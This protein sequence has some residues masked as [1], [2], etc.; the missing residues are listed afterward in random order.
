M[1]PMLCAPAGTRSLLCLPE[2]R[3]SCEANRA[4]ACDS[5]E[6]GRGAHGGWAL[7]VAAKRTISARQ[8]PRALVAVRKRG[9][10]QYRKRRHQSTRDAE[11]TSSVRHRTSENAAGANRSEAR[12][13]SI[14]ENASRALVQTVALASSAI[15]TRT[16]FSLQRDVCAPRFETRTRKAAHDEHARRDEES[17]SR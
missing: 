8:T 14:A 11:Q 3:L 1:K 16:V 9:R 17:E 5:N 6:V 12:C 10:A 7:S 15:N 4:R 13:R 2:W